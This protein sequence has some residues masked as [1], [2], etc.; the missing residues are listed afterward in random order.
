ML[1]E[2]RM[3]RMSSKKGS[4]PHEIKKPHHKTTHAEESVA[5]GDSS[6]VSSSSDK[7]EDSVHD[8]ADSG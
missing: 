2:M 5:S 7:D 4:I 3:L 8:A 1:Q 6:S